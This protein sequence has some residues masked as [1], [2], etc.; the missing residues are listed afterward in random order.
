MSGKHKYIV[1]VASKVVPSSA[2][3]FRAL[4]ASTQV[5]PLY[6]HLLPH[7][8]HSLEK[9]SRGVKN[10]FL[11]VERVY[12]QVCKLLTSMTMTFVLDI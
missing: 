7:T 3:S 4:C 9:H 8:S 12:R 10:V 6:L 2:F 1:G 5:T 11:E